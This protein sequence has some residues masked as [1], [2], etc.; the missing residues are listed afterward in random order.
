MFVVNCSLNK[1]EVLEIPSLKDDRCLLAN[2]H[3]KKAA[4]FLYSVDAGSFEVQMDISVL[5]C[6]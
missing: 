5:R 1:E 6:F 2:T 4:A 3:N